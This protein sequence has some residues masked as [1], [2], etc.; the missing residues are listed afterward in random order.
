MSGSMETLQAFKQ[1]VKRMKSYEEAISLMHWDL[2]TGGPRKGIPGR[3]EAIGELSTELFRMSVSED[4]GRY[5]EELGRE[6]VFQELDLTSQ[7]MVKEAKRSYDKS[8]KIPPERYQQFVVLTSNAEAAWEEA[9]PANDFAKLQPYLEQIV[10]FQREFIGLWGYEEHPYNT[11]LDM[12]EPGMTVAKLD[13]VF[14]E[15]RERLVPLVGA[16]AAKQLPDQPFLHRRYPKEQQRA[17]SLFLLR[18]L[19]YDLEAGRLDESAHPFMVSLNPGDARV[20]TRFD[21]DDIKYSV[22]STIH[23]CGHALY[24]QNI[25]PELGSTNLGSGTSMGIHESQSRFWENVVGRSRG[26]WT[27]YFRDFAA[28]FP[29]QL[30]GVTVDELYAGINEVK[31][32]LIRTESDELTYN[33]HIMIRYE[34]EKRLIG[35]ELQVADLPREWNRLYE[36]YLG[37]TPPSDTLGVLQDVHWSGGAFGYFPSYSLGNMYAA[38]M[39][40]TMRSD[41]PDMDALI[42]S[43]TFSPIL[44]W[45]KD[46]VYRHGKRKTPNELIRDISGEELDPSYLIRYLEEKYRPIYG[47]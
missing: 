16:I 33:L 46:R 34:L 31:A 5:L 21:E 35:G 3:S 45:L 27:R 30:E 19:G 11:L 8:V 20:T 42:E 24:E 17:F 32:S 26:F 13:A 47:I 2:R 40:H 18:E 6:D 10:D 41:L 9:K 25:D 29:E 12:Y 15:L 36:K 39:L 14:G 44:E 38:Q 1:L 37:I 28:M 23:E 4:M 22:F 7:R 43:G